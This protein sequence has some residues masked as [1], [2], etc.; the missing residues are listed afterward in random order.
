[1]VIKRSS[2]REVASLLEALDADD[3]LARETAVARLAVIGTR[4]V[5]GLLR[6]LSESQR[7]PARVG[8]LAALDAID[9]PR[10]VDAAFVGL[11][12]SSPEAR[13]AAVGMLRRLLD[14]RY[15]R[16]V[17]DRLVPLALD[18]A[19]PETLRLGA[20]DAL[21]GQAPHVLKPLHKALAADA[22]PAIRARLSA[23]TEEPPPDSTTVLQS[24]ADGALPDSPDHLRKAVNHAGADAPLP[25]LHR[26]IEA[27]RAR[28]SAMPEG[29]GRLAWMTVRAA[30]HQVLA[31]RGSTVALYDLRDTVA[32]AGTA[33]PVEMLAALGQ[34]G[35]RSCLEPIAGAYARLSAEAQQGVGSE[36]GGVAWW[37]DQLVAAFRA[38]AAREKIGERNPLTRRI[39]TR[40]PEAATR[41]FG[42]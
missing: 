20:L 23:G 31:S 11:R 6:V 18:S 15:D 4:A 1:M 16:E 5:D 35:D 26:L 27:V 33:V 36:A 25:I 34:I 30:V 21:G 17:L 13:T 29:P 8:A 12:D 7:P 28:E 39:R 32:A 9:D 10:A 19:L 14:S 24:A 37:Q 2:A 42:K 41:L 40:W 3:A 22:S 38:I